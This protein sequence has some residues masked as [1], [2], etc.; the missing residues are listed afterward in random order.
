MSFAI[1]IRPDEFIVETV[2]SNNEIPTDDAAIAHARPFGEPSFSAIV[3]KGTTVGLHNA[4]IAVGTFAAAIFIVA[5][6][7]S[8]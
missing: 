6:V 8:V 1:F 3:S 2:V 7:V 4:Y 5:M